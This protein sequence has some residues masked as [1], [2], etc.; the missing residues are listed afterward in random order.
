MTDQMHE[1]QGP[2]RVI[3]AAALRRFVEALLETSGSPPERAKQIADVFVEADLRGIGLQGLDHVPTILR[4]IR[5]GK[6]RL[7]AE[8]TVSRQRSGAILLDT[9]GAPGPIGAIRAAEHAI[10]AARDHGIAA[11]GV[12][13]GNDLYLL[14][15]YAEKIA[16]AG[17]VGIVLTTGHALVHPFGGVERM[18]ATNPLAIA[19]PRPGTDPFL[20]EMATSA[21]A[22]GRVRQAA[23]Y[24]QTLPEGIGLGPDGKPSRDA[25]T[26]RAGAI[27]PMA[28]HKGYA[29]SLS[30]ALLAGPLIGAV[31]GPARNDESGWTG[32]PGQ[33]LIAIDPTAFGEQ[34]RF[35]GS[36]ENYLQEIKAS[37]P[38]EGFAEVRIPGERA[39]RERERR[40]REGV[41]IPE[42]VVDRV[43]LFAEELGVEV[44]GTPSNP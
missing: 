42:V 7:T 13:A 5:S 27:A 24:G 39:F 37:R 35:L 21:L 17:F 31:V 22:A 19:V 41:P 4:E 20:M 3:S 32:A 6:V 10:G 29:L 2:M 9:A 33:L 16:R 28:G 34:E 11:V 1:E 36:V 23:Y 44:P 8:V 18:L 38:A 26:I 15:Y 30:I 14:G 25:A 40:L 12:A 43:R